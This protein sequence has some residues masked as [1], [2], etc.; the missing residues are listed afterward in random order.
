M[1][2][3]DPTQ[4]SEDEFSALESRLAGAL[5]PIRPPQDSIRKLRARIQFPTR[6]ELARRLGDWRRLFFA[7]AAVLTG[8]MAL[9]TLARALYYLTG[10]RP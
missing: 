9:V 5:R 7:L 8:M 3:R 6:E 10:R 4:F 1:T 2:E